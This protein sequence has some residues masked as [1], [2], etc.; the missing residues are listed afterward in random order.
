MPVV[1]GT[2]RVG[3]INKPNLLY[4]AAVKPLLNF[5]ADYAMS[6]CHQI[7]W[8]SRHPWYLGTDT[9]PEPVSQNLKLKGSLASLVWP[10]ASPSLPIKKAFKQGESVK[11]PIAQLEHKM[12][13]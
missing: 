2:D 6:R 8:P 1:L 10:R 7:H 5:L 4:L 12:Y 13:L 11:L 9:V 3:G